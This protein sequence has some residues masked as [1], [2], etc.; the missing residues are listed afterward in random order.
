[1][2]SAPGERAVADTASRVSASLALG[3]LCLTL[4]ASFA[5]SA[6]PALNA[7]TDPSDS[8]F[9]QELLRRT[10]EKR[11]ARVIERLDDYNRRNF[12]D[13]FDVVDKGYNGRK[14]T[15]NDEAI[16]AQGVAL[17]EGVLVVKPLLGQC[18]VLGHR[19]STKDLHLVL[20]DLDLLLHLGERLRGGLDLVDVLVPV[21]LDDVVQLR[22]LT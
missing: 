2:T 4:S 3:T 5:A 7:P 21:R 15:E 12:K 13:Y 1:M 14:L 8:P 19:L 18:L 16:R 20:K 17:R 22:E 6:A 11:E 10:E 9:V